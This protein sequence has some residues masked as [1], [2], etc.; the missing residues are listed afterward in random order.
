MA[1]SVNWSTGVITV[2]KVDM[3]LVQT[4]PYD[5]YELD[6]NQFRLALKDLEDDVDGIA[7]QRTHNH[8]PPVT[9]GGVTIARSVEILSPYTVT[10]EADRDWETSNS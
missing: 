4:T 9:F 5:V 8:N 2:N 10:F 3:T 6:V 7:F 1:I